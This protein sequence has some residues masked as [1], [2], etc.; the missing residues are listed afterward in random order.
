MESGD[1]AWV[2]ESDYCRIEICMGPGD[3]DVV[4]ELES[5]YCRIEMTEPGTITSHLGR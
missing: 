1:Y 2:L 3:R 5:D 4:R